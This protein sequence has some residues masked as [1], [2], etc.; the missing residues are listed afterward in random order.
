M[1]DIVG[2]SRRASV[3]NDGCKCNYTTVLRLMIISIRVFDVFL[4]LVVIWSWIEGFWVVFKRLLQSWQ[5]SCKSYHGSTLLLASNLINLPDRLGRAGFKWQR[6]TRIYKIPST[7]VSG[8][9]LNEKPEFHRASL[10]YGFS[11]WWDKKCGKAVAEVVDGG[12]IR[13]EIW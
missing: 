13:T 9:Q 11:D 6:K 4:A 3:I 1:L 7:P 2:N 12:V 10:Q 8:S 5:A